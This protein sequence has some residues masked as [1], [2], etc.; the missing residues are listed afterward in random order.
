MVPYTYM[1]RHVSV[2]TGCA[3]IVLGDWGLCT[4]LGYLVVLVGL[5]LGGYF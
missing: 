5:D 2:H 4:L 3:L 1:S